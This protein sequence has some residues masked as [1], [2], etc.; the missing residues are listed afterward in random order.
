MNVGT[1][2]AASQNSQIVSMRPTKTKRSH[3]MFA[4]EQWWC[5]VTA[6]KRTI[7]TSRERAEVRDILTKEYRPDQDT[8]RNREQV[9]LGCSFF[10]FNQLRMREQRAVQKSLAV[11]ED[12]AS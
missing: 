8:S 4:A 11:I 7:S 1:V 10:P 12:C 2:C 6:K 9:F 5:V 3:T